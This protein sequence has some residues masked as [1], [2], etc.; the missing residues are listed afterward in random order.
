MITTSKNQQLRLDILRK[1]YY[2]DCVSLT[3]LSKLTSK[4]LPVITSAVNEIIT[5]GYLIEHG[6]APSTGGRR[7]AMFLFNKE[8][9]R[10]VVSVAMDQ[11]VS[12][13]AIYDLSKQCIYP[14]QNIKLNPFEDKEGLT[15]LI[16]FIDSH[17]SKSGLNRDHIL[18]IGVG[19]P[20][21]VNSDKGINESFFFTERISL[22]DYLSSQI[23]LP[24]YIDNDSCLIAQAELRFGAGIGIK[25]L[26]VVNIGWGTGLGMIVNGQIFKGHSGY[27][28]EFSHIPLSQSNNLCSCG[29]RGCLEVETSV[30]TMVSKAKAAIHDGAES[31]M[32]ELFQDPD[33]LPGDGFLKAAGKGDPLALSIL[34]ES[35]FQLGKGLSTLIHIMNPERIVLSGRGAVVGKM[36]LPAIQQAIYEFSIPKIAEQTTLV[37]S[38]LGNEAELIGAASLVIDNS[39]FE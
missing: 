30:L 32:S 37:V 22:R 34:A 21:F 19:M 2:K 26:M 23:K 35:A 8:K 10:Y 27:A 33:D 18:G 5:E 9:P 29:K 28:G 6:L 7:P 20:G 3:E 25:E 13:I 14:I 12:R 39:M 4:S 11:L 16:S 15:K 17:I 24:V 1:V 31:I 38:D 36:F